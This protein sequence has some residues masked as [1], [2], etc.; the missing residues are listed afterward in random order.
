MDANDDDDGT[1][2]SYVIDVASNFPKLLLV[3]YFK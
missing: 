2:K 3:E 1:N